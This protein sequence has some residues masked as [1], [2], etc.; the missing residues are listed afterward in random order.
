MDRYNANLAELVIKR[1]HESPMPNL[2]VGHIENSESLEPVFTA[3]ERDHS[4]FK[5]GCGNFE[6]DEG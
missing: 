3:C 6:D 5:I 1:N 4:G 2:V